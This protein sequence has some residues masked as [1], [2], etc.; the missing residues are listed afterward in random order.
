MSDQEG[1]HTPRIR[2]SFGVADV[3]K[4]HRQS[5]SRTSHSLRA[6]AARNAE[7]INNHKGPLKLTDRVVAMMNPRKS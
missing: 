2:K 1:S 7:A 4:L 6:W 3:R 5:S